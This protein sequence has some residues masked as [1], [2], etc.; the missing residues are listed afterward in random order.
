MD[1]QNKKRV[2]IC[3][4]GWGL[5]HA[6]RDIPIIDSIQKNGHKVIIAGDQLQL[7]LLSQR[8]EGIETILF[9]SFKVKFS[10]EQSQILPLIWIAL[11]LPYHFIKEHLVLKRLIRQHKINLVISD[12]RFGLWNDGIKTIIITHQ[13]KVFLP[14]PFRILEPLGTRVI[15]YMVEKFDSCW[16]PDYSDSNNLAGELSHPKRLP[17]NASYV[18]IL[19]RFYEVKT[20]QLPDTWDL[21]GF[22]SGPSPHREIFIT[23]M[24]KLSRKHNIKTLIIKGNPNE[25]VNITEQNG[26]WYAGHLNDSEFAETVKSA[27]YLICRAGYSSVMDMVA[28]GTKCLI[29][30]TPGQTEQEYLTEFLSIKGLFKTCKQNEIEKIDISIAVSTN[31]YPNCTSYLLEKTFQEFQ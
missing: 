3:P 18:G 13:L 16:I 24:E 6:S 5:G 20:M 26:I 27:K 11:R 30:P 23:E 4:L 28:L 15:R 8:F 9:P 17:K 21:V 1:D 2:L 14:R 10:K 22:V 31:I 29:V 7:N 25:G 12:N 19:S